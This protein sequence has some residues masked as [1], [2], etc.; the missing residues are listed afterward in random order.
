MMPHDG[1]DP[2]QMPSSTSHDA[3]L[4]IQ[5]QALSGRIN[6][7][8]EIAATINQSL[9][10]ETI[11]AIVQNHVKWLLDFHYCSI[12]LL[13][14]D[15]SHTVRPLHNPDAQP[16]L[17]ALERALFRQTMT[18]KAPQRVENYA[19]VL[20]QAA[21]QTADPAQHL[22]SAPSELVSHYGSWLAMPIESQSQV[23]GV[24]LF[25]HEEPNVYS[26]EDLRIAHL[27]A[28][29]LANAIANA[30][31]FTEVAELYAQLEHAY[32]DLQR[33][34]EL[35]EDM[36]KMVIHDLRNPLNVIHISL[37]LIDEF[38]NSAERP[39]VRASIKRAKRAGKLMHTMIADLLDFNKL[40]SAEFQLERTP[41]DLKLLLLQ[42][43][44]EWKLRADLQDKQFTLG[45]IPT[46]PPIWCNARL[47]Q[48][49]LDNLLNNAFKYTVAGNAIALSFTL[50]QPFL[51]THIQDNGMGIPHE[52]QQRIFDKFVQVAAGTDQSQPQG[53]GLGLAFC[54]LVVETHGGT[55][56]VESTPQAGSKFTFSLPLDAPTETVPTPT[57]LL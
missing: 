17:Q 52:Y 24:M 9:D 50:E 42:L 2:T 39:Q 28:I 21:E 25:G 20:D 13:T 33:A 57:A 8:N 1:V 47:L 19:L 7:I 56:F 30:K 27:L 46:L 22:A 12:G 15:G 38:V 11:L 41:T 23:W 37:D 51:Y 32:E 44:D 6:A 31:R 4:A 36:I 45:A 35:R 18:T 5:L 53:S 54:K 55:I 40:E 26:T 29:Q 49:V 10:L 16:T 48:R 43:F 3:Q 14:E 34:E